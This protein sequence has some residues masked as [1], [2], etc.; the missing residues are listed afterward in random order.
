MMIVMM[1]GNTAAH[2]QGA[3]VPTRKA[4]KIPTVTENCCSEHNPPLYLGDAI[5]EMYTLKKIGKYGKF[6]RCTLYLDE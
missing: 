3:F 4:A 6:S 1:T 2:R 5:S